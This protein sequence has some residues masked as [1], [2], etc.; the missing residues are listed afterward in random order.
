MKIELTR[1]MLITWLRKIFREKCSLDM[2]S[3]LDVLKNLLTVASKI[4]INLSPV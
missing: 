1:N 3:N 4:V 2:Q